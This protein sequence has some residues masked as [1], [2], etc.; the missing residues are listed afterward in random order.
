M[1][2]T[3]SLATITRLVLGAIAGTLVKDGYLASS[4][5]EAFIGAGMLVATGAWGLWNGYGKDIATASLELLRAR[6]MNAAAVARANPVIAPS[7]IASVAAHVIATA[8]ASVV[9]PNPTAPAIAAL[10]LG[11]AL[12]GLLQPGVAYAQTPTPRPFVPTGN[13]VKDIQ[14]SKQGAQ[15]AANE[16]IDDLV[17]KLDKLALPDF[18]FALAQAMAA[19]NNVTIPCWSAWV[20]LIKARQAAAI[21]A[22][23]QPIPVPDPHVI[24]AIERIS[25]L[26]AILRPDSKISLACVQIAATA[27]KDVGTV[28]AGILSGGALGMFKLPIPIGPIP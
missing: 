15:A 10:I 26:L 1:N 24:T 27:G 23:G 7:A 13:L 21:D 5:S 22:S 17:S 20:D 3:T 4:G 9:V 19:N 16:G 18:E 12:L 2:A 8:P 6:V 28:I 11:T 25:E 14:T